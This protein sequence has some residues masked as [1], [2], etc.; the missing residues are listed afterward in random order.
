[1]KLGG[2]T[3]GG[4]TEGLGVSHRLTSCTTSTWFDPVVFVKQGQ[5]QIKL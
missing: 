3:G 2:K 5:N 4:E 1:M